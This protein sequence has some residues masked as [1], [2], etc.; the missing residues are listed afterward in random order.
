MLNIGDVGSFSGE[1]SEL[2]LWIKSH[3]HRADILREANDA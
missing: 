2:D 3:H 1:K